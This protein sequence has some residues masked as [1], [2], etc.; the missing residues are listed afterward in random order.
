MDFNRPRFR[1]PTTRLLPATSRQLYPRL[2][3]GY[4]IATERTGTTVVN[5]LAALAE[6][7]DLTA[8]NV[9]QADFRALLEQHIIAKAGPAYLANARQAPHLAGTIGLAANAFT[10]GERGALD[11]VAQASWNQW[12]A[13]ASDPNSDYNIYWM[14]G[15][16]VSMNRDD[17]VS[18]WA[19]AN[20]TGWWNDATAAQAAYTLLD[21]STSGTTWMGGAT[22]SSKL[23][24]SQWSS[25]FVKGWTALQKGVT[26]QVLSIAYLDVL[27]KGLLTAPAQRRMPLFQAPPGNL[28]ATDP[29]AIAFRCLLR[30]LG[31]NDLVRTWYTYT[32]QSWAAQ[33]EAQDAQDAT[34]AAAI[35]ALNYVSG[36][37]VYDQLLSRLNDYWSARAD[38]A[39][40]IKAF[41]TLAKGPLRG[42]IPQSDVTAMAAI[43][44]TF[45]STDA[46]AVSAVSPLGLW[47]TSQPQGASA[48]NG[49]HGVGD[50]GLVQVIAAGTV[51]V[52]ALG[53]V[54]YIVATM[55]ATARA[56]AAQVKATT[57]SILGTVDQLKQS[58]GRV[59]MASAKGA[60]D[61]AKYQDCLNSTKALTDSIPPVPES[62]SDP[63]GIGKIAMLLG[64]GVV[65]VV[66]LTAMKN[67]KS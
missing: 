40:N 45:L 60:A 41:D 49:L 52:A 18:A 10:Q 33:S 67:K 15:R 36:K 30:Q 21:S 34:Y 46:R 51:A 32:A 4:G 50:L 24:N 17:L 54:A 5:G 55:T 35:T 59:Y 53:V 13:A 43:R 29:A 62:S 37:A 11:P 47:P 7:G 31:W 56:A 14:F 65:G 25:I 64:V 19:T 28:P 66:A 39:A 27:C 26:G 1:A 48:L 57:D 42:Q 9:A 3:I 61:E 58:C 20:Q 16:M 8:G 22:V 38:A 2:A 23:T 12:R 44:Q 6:F 63:L